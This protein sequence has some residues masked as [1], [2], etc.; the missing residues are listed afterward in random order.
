MLS[1]VPAVAQLSSSFSRAEVIADLHTLQQSLENAHY[2]LYAYT[3]K[4]TFDSTYQAIESSIRQDSL[5]LLAT[6]NLFQG[7][8]STVNNGHSNLDFPIQSYGAYAYASGTIFPLEL[9]FEDGKSWVNGSPAAEGIIPDIF[10]KNH[11]L[12]EQDEIL[13]GLLQKIQGI[14]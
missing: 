11:L 1:A 4:Q 2:N 12:D 10:I 13:E 14:E 6:I 5:S 7:L 8:V 3:T 9:A